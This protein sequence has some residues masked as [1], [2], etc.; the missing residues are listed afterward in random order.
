MDNG[1]AVCGG[2]D[3]RGPN[4][5]KNYGSGIWMEKVRNGTVRRCIGLYAQNG[6]LLFDSDHCLVT[7]ND[8]SCNSGWGIGLYQSSDNVVSWNLT[9]F[10]IRPGC[11]DSASIVAD[12]RLQPQLLRR[13]FDD[14]RRR[15][16]LPVEPDRRRL[17]SQDQGVPSQR[18]LRTTTSSPTTTARGRRATHLRGPSPIATSTTRT[19]A[20]DSGYGFWLGY[21]CDTLIADNEINHNRADGIAIEQGHGNLFEHNTIE[22]TAGTAVHLWAV[23]AQRRRPVRTSLPRISRSATTPS[24]RRE[25]PLTWPTARTTTSATTPWRRRLFPRSDQHQAA[26]PDDRSGPFPRVRAGQEARRDPRD[27]AEGV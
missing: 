16:L 26:K 21:S 27:Q 19:I 10:V 15:R 6:V 2:L 22:D 11:G 4:A 13:Q 1:K 12:E 18:L 23:A 9:D 7:D 24:A 3:L 25:Q 8:F 17:G 14:A 20:N 5:W